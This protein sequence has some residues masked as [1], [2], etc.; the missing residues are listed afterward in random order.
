MD[1]LSQENYAKL[2]AM[3]LSARFTIYDYKKCSLPLALPRPTTTTS[4]YLGVRPED[5]HVEEEEEAATHLFCSP[6]SSSAP[7]IAHSP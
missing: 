2:I 6:S 1:R 3:Q 5:E 7:L 4:K